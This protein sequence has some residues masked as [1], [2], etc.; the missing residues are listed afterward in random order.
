M[1]KSAI[2]KEKDPAAR[3]VEVEPLRIYRMDGHP[4]DAIDLPPSPDFVTYAHYP[5]EYSD[6]E[7][8]AKAFEE[9]G[10]E[11]WYMSNSGKPCVV[12]FRRRDG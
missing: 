6:C 4:A 11:V 7:H 1:M 3:W 5:D 2:T 10:W 8:M 12:V 9:D